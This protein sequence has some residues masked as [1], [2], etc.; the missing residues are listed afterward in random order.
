MV[1]AV[2]IDMAC[3]ASLDTEVESSRGFPW[4]IPLRPS[5]TWTSF[6][7]GSQGSREEREKSGPHM[8]IYLETGMEMNSK[9]YVGRAFIRVEA[10]WKPGQKV[11]GSQGQLYPYNE[12]AKVVVTRWPG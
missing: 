3:R 2:A 12:E 7:I 11:V 10:A 4:L 8:I 9:G 6:E 1:A 5:L